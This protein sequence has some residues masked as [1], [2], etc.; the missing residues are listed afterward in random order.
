MKRI[1]SLITIAIAAT[2]LLLI[3]PAAAAERPGTRQIH[4]QKRIH[5]GVES[6]EITRKEYRNLQREQA[7][8]QR[9]KRQAWSD[10]QLTRKE[11][12]RLEH[13]QNKSSRHIYR[14][15]HNTAD[16]N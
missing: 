9:S 4:Q 5:Q 10:G 16:R 8:I 12:V 6:G 11:R 13:Q 1:C 7:A 14:A 3:N 2:S 15:K